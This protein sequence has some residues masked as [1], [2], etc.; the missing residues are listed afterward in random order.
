MLNNKTRQVEF[1][2][3]NI[4][5][6][7]WVNNNHSGSYP[8][9]SLRFMIKKGFNIILLMVIILMAFFACQK[10]EEAK[11][12]P[13]LSLNGSS[14]IYLKQGCEF[15]DPGVSVIDDKDLGN[16][17]IITVDPETLPDTAGTYY[18]K[19]TA[20]DSDGNISYAER[21]VIVLIRESKEYEG[22]YLVKDS[23]FS[24]QSSTFVDTTSFTSIID[25]KSAYPQWIEIF[26]FN[27]FGPH[28]KAFLT[29][30]SAGTIN[31]SFQLHDTAITGIGQNSCE[32]NS[33]TLDYS[34]KTP[35]DSTFHR[36]I[37]ILSGQK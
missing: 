7:F 19:Y 8:A 9:I 33:F 1:I 6:G 15:V 23:V 27:N 2:A 3:M 21:K 20:E 18:V 30:D 22:T 16:E 12:P 13:S 28:F 24:S 14:V 34:V 17:I 10:I 25:M 29:H 11:I 5:I 36:S 37:F 35:A 26:N 4:N 32:T 31:V